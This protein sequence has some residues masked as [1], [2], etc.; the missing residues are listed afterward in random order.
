MKVANKAIRVQ[1]VQKKQG[2]NSS[3]CDSVKVN[4]D[5]RQVNELLTT[6]TRQSFEEKQSTAARGERKQD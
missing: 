5:H 4:A 3:A 6:A 2:E 1:F